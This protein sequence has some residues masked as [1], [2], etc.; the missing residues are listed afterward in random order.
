M[1][2][3]CQ[4]NQK[5]IA[6]FE[7]Q[8]ADLKAQIEEEKLK[9]A[10]EAESKKIAE[11]ERASME[12]EL[13]KLKFD[14][15]KVRAER[16]KKL[17]TTL[18]VSIPQALADVSKFFAEIDHYPEEVRQHIYNSAKTLANEIADKL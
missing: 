11:A 18:T 16:V 10:E 5:S 12:K 13:Q 8:I 7:Q 17:S 6:N 15:A 14:D 3:R 2:K 9:T 1:L 4:P